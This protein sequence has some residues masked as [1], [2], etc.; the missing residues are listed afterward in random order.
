MRTMHK[1]ISLAIAAA[2]VLTITSAIASAEEGDVIVRNNFGG[3]SFDNFYG[4]TGVPGGFVAVGY[5]WEESFNTG[6]W[7]GVTGKGGEDAIIVRFDNNGNVVW[8]KNFGGA[9][10]DQFWGV[11]A[12][13]GGVVAVGESYAAS[14]GNGDW[15]GVNGNVRD[16]A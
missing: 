2:F 8:R 1:C 15:E 7:A 14:F 10:A 16:S 6:D 13:P 11:T 9:G 4:V 3:G 5:S 12:V